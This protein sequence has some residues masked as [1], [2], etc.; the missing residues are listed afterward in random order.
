MEHRQRKSGPFVEAYERLL[1][2][3]GP[4]D[5]WPGETPF[6]VMVGAILTQNTSWN[7]VEK[8]IALLKSK[9]LL[10]PRRMASL[11]QEELA[12]LIRSSGY[13]NQKAKKLLAF[14][15]WYALY[16]FSPDR[17]RSS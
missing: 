10:T 7:N 17:I 4:S 6:E 5:W 2:R 11:P 16:Q 3:L 15:D 9:N 8:S 12:A 14:L 13:F 1:H